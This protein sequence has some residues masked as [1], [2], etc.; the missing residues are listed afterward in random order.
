VKRQAAG[1]RLRQQRHCNTVQQ[2]LLL[3]SASLQGCLQP[4]C[5]LLHCP[6][7]S[8]RVLLR[9]R[10]RQQQ[11]QHLSKPPSQ[12]TRRPA[13]ALL[14]RQMKQRMQDWVAAVL[15]VSQLSRAAARTCKKQPPASSSSSRV[16]Q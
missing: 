1:R 8:V 10:K 7:L 4:P 15:G 9:S 14:N 12:Q 3:L 16:L 5:L 6:S 2:Q 11:L 13:A